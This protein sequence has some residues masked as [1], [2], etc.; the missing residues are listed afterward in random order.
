MKSSQYLES[1][2][3]IIHLDYKLSNIM[4]LY[5]S[6]LIKKIKDDVIITDKKESS[7][8]KYHNSLSNKLLDPESDLWS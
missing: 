2:Y 6:D 7:H 8:K 5:H 1:K 4:Y 3:N